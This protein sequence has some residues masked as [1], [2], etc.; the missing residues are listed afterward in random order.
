MLC[1]CRDYIVLG[2]YTGMYRAYGILD[3]QIEKQLDN[4]MEIKLDT[5]PTQ[6]QLDNKL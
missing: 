2:G 3:N 1:L 5:A 4:E 6:K